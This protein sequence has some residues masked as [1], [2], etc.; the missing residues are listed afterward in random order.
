M[1]FIFLFL[2]ESNSREFLRKEIDSVN[3][4][5]QKAVRRVP[6][7]VGFGSPSYKYA[8]QTVNS[9]PGHQKKDLIRNDKVFFS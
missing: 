3:Q 6:K 9:R 7:S 1:L 2:G 4:F 5:Q 8:K